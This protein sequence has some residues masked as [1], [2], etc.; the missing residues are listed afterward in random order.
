VDAALVLAEGR[1]YAKGYADVGTGAAAPAPDGRV[2]A[3]EHGW[4]VIRPADTYHRSVETSWCRECGAKRRR[5]LVCIDHDPAGSTYDFD[6]SQTEIALPCAVPDGRVAELATYLRKEVAEFARAMEDELRKHDAARGATGWKQEPI[7][8]LV[9]R[10]EEE[11]TEFRLAVKVASPD[12]VMSEAADVGN[13][14]MM[15]SD[16]LAALLGRESNPPSGGGEE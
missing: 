3:C 12:V 14:A 6:E 13:L 2:A 11:M 15:V 4:V 8:Y 10:L 1:G 5:C 16:A 7:D 9:E